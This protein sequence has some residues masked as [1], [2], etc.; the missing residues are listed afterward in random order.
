VEVA[1]PNVSSVAFVGR[2]QNVL[3]ITTAREGLSPEQ[4]AEFPHS[5]LLFTAQV[6]V[7]GHPTTPWVS[8]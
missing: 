2:D 7:T 8:R 1:A 6:D 3:L 4:L 5:G